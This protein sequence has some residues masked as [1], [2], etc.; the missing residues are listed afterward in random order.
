[1]QI[2]TKRRVDYI[3]GLM[4]NDE[5]KDV[6]EIG[7]GRGEI[8][9]YIASETKNFVLGTD[10]CVPFIELAKSG[11]KRDN[12][13]FMV[14]DFNKPEEIENRKFDYVIGNGILHHLYYNIDE[15]LI[16]LRK[17]LKSGGKIIFLEPNLLNPYCYMIFNT[18]PFFRKMAKLEPTEKAFSR[19]F[20][21]KKLI[22]NQFVD[23]D[24]KYKDFLLPVIP[25]PLIKFVI[26]VGDFFEKIPFVRAIS[27]SLFIS[28]TGTK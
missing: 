26:I 28:A 9:N 27:Q 22:K 10:I 18:L 2:R 20:I 13:E 11:Y 8:S 14:L 23:I 3:I 4:K 24:V 1:M 15:T 5:K 16:N 19:K 6:L 17:L 25:K 7:C 21:I 12:L